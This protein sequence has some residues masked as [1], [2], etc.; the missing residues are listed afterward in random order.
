MAKHWKD[1]R[2]KVVSVVGKT[3]EISV[4]HDILGFLTAKSH[5]TNS[6]INID[7]ALKYPL[8]PAPLSLAHADG[9]KRKTTKGELAK[10]ALSSEEVNSIPHDKKEVYILDLAAILT[11]TAKVSNTLRRY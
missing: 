5:E 8:C 11:S 4:Q 6:I 3:L 7:E 9:E 1:S 2:A 10:Y